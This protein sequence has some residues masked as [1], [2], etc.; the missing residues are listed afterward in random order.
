[1]R[2]GAAN[3]WRNERGM[4]ELDE[5]RKQYEL[6][7]LDPIRQ[8]LERFII[9]H[10]GAIETYR[11]EQGSKGIP[12][13]DEAAVK[14]YILRHR[15]INPRREIQD[16]IEEIMKEK[17]IRGVRTGRAPDEREVVAEWSREHSAAWRA[18]RV[19][20]I[21]YVFE[22]EKDRLVKLLSP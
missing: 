2:R 16:Q 1:M 14:F 12:L 13:T 6:G 10:R 9:A 17:W 15:S 8:D 3:G 4:S 22:R 19:T 18:H 11:V 5:I 21:I 20:V 7:R